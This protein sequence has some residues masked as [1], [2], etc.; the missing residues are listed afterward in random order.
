MSRSVHRDGS[1]SVPVCPTVPLK[2]SVRPL[3]DTLWPLG[4][5]ALPIAEILR[6]LLHCFL[7]NTVVFFPTLPSPENPPKRD[8][9]VSVREQA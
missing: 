5:H 1:L 9:E 4:E 2:P 7:V 6:W 3:Q 8:L